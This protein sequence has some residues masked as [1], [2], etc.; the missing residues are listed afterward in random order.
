MTSEKLERASILSNQILDLT[1][2]YLNI[3]IPEKSETLDYF[4]LAGITEKTGI[5][6]H[7]EFL[8]VNPDDVIIPYLQNVKNKIADLQAEFDKL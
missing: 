4:L 2:H 6:L 1:N 5:M 8:F 7:R 3:G